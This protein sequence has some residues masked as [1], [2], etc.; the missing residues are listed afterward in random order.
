MELEGEKN[1]QFCYH[2][3]SYFMSNETKIY[4][5]KIEPLA[6]SL[7]YTKKLCDFVKEK[8]KCTSSNCLINC[9]FLNP[10]PFKSIQNRKSNCKSK[11]CGFSVEAKE[12]KD[13]PEWIFVFIVWS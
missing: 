8:R 10:F 6:N 11:V 13:S 3:T 12:K 2:N 9:Q 5:K 7:A 1:E 4:R